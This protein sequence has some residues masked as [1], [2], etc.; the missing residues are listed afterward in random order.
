MSTPPVDDEKFFKCS[1]EL[2]FCIK[3]LLFRIRRNKE[4]SK[5]FG[6]L[7]NRLSSSFE[8]MK[9]PSFKNQIGKIINFFIFASQNSIEIDLNEF[10]KFYFEYRKNS[11]G[12]EISNSTCKIDHNSSYKPFLNKSMLQ[13]IS[14]DE[15]N[16]YKSTN[17]QIYPNNENLDHSQNAISEK[18]TIPILIDFFDGLFLFL[19]V[20]LIMP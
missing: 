4:S 3:K 18:E 19:I 7:V 17:S 2:S 13:N 16:K 15:Y 11:S 20:S 1:P 8:V 6:M 12:I 9:I 5:V 10:L 14:A